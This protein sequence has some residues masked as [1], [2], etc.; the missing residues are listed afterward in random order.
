MIGFL[1]AVGFTS[2]SRQ[3]SA[4]WP[5][6][7]A[8]DGCLGGGGDENRAEQTRTWCNMRPKLLLWRL[9]PEAPS[10]QLVGHRQIS[11]PQTLS[12]T[13]LFQRLP[14]LAP[15]P[16]LKEAIQQLCLLS[17]YLPLIEAL[18]FAL[19]SWLSFFCSQ[20]LSGVFEELLYFLDGLVRF[21]GSKAGAAKALRRLG[22]L[23]P[24]VLAWEAALANAEVAGGNL[25]KGAEA[26]TDRP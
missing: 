2:L 24:A 21:A 19:G 17:A 15:R 14:T 3:H 13:F 16:N 9:V 25:S 4:S 1:V 6:A 23:P 26:L 5:G 8:A 11:R 10:G 12:A 22:D 18:L 7:V 20:L